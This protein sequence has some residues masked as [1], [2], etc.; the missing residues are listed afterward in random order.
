MAFPKID[1]AHGSLVNAVNDLTKV[2]FSPIPITVVSVNEKPGGQMVVF[3][4]A[5][6]SIHEVATRLRL[7]ADFLEGQE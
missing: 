7:A 3:D 4:G 2:G 6:W 1:A 5:K